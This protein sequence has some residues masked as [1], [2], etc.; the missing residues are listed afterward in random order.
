MQGEYLILLAVILT[1]VLLSKLFFRWTAW[2]EKRAFFWTL[3]IPAA[4][5]VF[6]D[7]LVTGFFWD[8]NAKYVLPW[9][10]FNLPYEEVGF[11]LTVPFACLFL[12][13]NIQKFIADKEYVWRKTGERVLISIFIALSALF[14]LQELWYTGAICLLM[15]LILLIARRAGVNLIFGK[16]QVIFLVLVLILTTIFNGYLTWRP[17]VVYNPL[18]KTGLNVFTIPVEDY[19]YGFALIFFNLVIYAKLKKK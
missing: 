17:I 2:P 5:F 4:I 3:F 7:I 14:F 13:S 6:L 1:S 18:I 8:F 19:I 12:W 10:F 11:F 9:R 15:A 16:Q